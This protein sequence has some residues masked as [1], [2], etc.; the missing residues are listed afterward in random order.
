MKSIWFIVYISVALL[1]GLLIPFAMF[2]YETDE[3]D[4]K[5]D[6]KGGI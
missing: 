1:A 4:D 6:K 3:E 2:Y 5:K